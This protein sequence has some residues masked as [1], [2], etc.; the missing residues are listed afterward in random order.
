MERKKSGVFV[1]ELCG[2]TGS[3]PGA[4]PAAWLHE[5]LNSRE[6]PGAASISREAAGLVVGLY[7]RVEGGARSPTGPTEVW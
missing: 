4:K 6:A 3:G 1:G 5:Y 2:G 7:G